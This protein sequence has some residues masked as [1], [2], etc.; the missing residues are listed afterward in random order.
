MGEME[1]IR[2]L[3]NLRPRHRDC[4]ATIGNYDGIHLGHQHIFG[5]LKGKSRVLGVPTTVISFEP[6]AKEFFSRERLP[7]ARLTRFREKF[8]VLRDLGIDR[9]LVMRFNEALANFTS[10]EFIDRVLVEGLGVRCLVVGDDFRFGRRRSGNLE[11][12]REAGARYGFS[13]ESAPQVT[14]DGMRVSSGEIRRALEEGRLG[15][16]TRL[17]G[18]PYRISGR[19]VPG[20]KLGRELGFPTANIKLKRQV[21]PLSGI[22]AVRVGGIDHGARPGVA[23]LGT[24]PTVQGEEP[25]LEVHV[26]DWQQSLY[27]RYLHVDFIAK[28]REEEHFASVE[29]M[30]KQ[31]GQDAEQARAILAGT[32]TSKQ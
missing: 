8:E 31:M 21:M 5:L 22:F 3:S 15:L 25:L 19:V 6:T 27:G 9:F 7:P 12:L 13:V 30:Q 1:L 4:V 24:R 16:A 17:L 14:L 2:G 20:R 10:D 29:L 18:R 26:F 23:S 28:L 32:P 11:T